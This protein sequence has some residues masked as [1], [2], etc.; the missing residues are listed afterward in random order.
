MGEGGKMSLPSRNAV[1]TV[2]LVPNTIVNKTTP[3][4]STMTF[5]IFRNKESMTSGV[6]NLEYIEK[7]PPTEIGQSACKVFETLYPYLSTAE[8]IQVNRR[9]NDDQRTSDVLEALQGSS[10]IRMRGK[11]NQSGVEANLPHIAESVKRGEPIPLN[12][13]YG[14]A[15]L[16]DVDD[17]R[18]NCADIADFSAI[19]SLIYLNDRVKTVYPAG[20]VARV[21]F[22][23]V[24][25]YWLFGN[26]PAIKRTQDKYYYSLVGMMEGM[27]PIYG[28][29][30][31]RFVRESDI[32]ESSGHSI[33]DFMT[34]ARRLKPFFEAY[35]RESDELMEKRI[36]NTVYGTWAEAQ[37][38]LGTDYARYWDNFAQSYIVGLDSYKALANEG[39][40]GTIP[41]ETRAFYFERF[42][43]NAQTVGGTY[44]ALVSY[45]AGYDASALTKV[46]MGTTR[47]L[48]PGENFDLKNSIKV[49]LIKLPP[50][51]PPTYDGVLQMRSILNH[52]GRGGA[53]TCAAPWRITAGIL[54]Y[55]SENR[56]R[57]EV[58]ST[59]QTPSG[60]RYPADA[61]LK[62][63][64]VRIRADVGV[65][66]GD[67]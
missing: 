64:G 52:S 12:L 37:S 4:L 25:G 53:D 8:G 57:V 60:E 56:S 38:Q 1:N 40:R 50:G 17:P 44:D 2:K 10:R 24:V 21:Y 13:V 31:I 26:N 55:P 49:S 33:E 29:P 23:D 58:A 5:S 16:P 32:L 62:E 3:L 43:T 11:L 39:W 45:L 9:S 14:T 22:E 42:K 7:C 63:S 65:S 67:N 47:N 54:V 15:K 48:L 27:E 59:W 41:P 30:S 61:V 51:T 6:S 20:T 36:S 34:E 19:H 46:H 28:R 66:R 35:L 18:A